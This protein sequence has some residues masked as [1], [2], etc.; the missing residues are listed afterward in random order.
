MR[1]EFK[2]E[3]ERMFLNGTPQKKIAE[4]LGCSKAKVYKTIQQS[5]LIQ[6]MRIKSDIIYHLSWRTWRLKISSKLTPVQRR[7]IKD[8]SVSLAVI[9]KQIEKELKR[10]ND[11]SSKHLASQSMS[12][13]T[14]DKHF[15]V[16]YRPRIKNVQKSPKNTTKYRLQNHI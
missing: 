16:I 15:T 2:T 9:E 5:E 3:V 6:C 12:F 4:L 14:L 1:A 8:L 10:I 11:V 7:E 13:D